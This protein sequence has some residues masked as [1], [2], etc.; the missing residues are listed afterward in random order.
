[1]V[2]GFIMSVEA[3]GLF[4]VIAP[5]SAK[6]KRPP[7]EEE[8][9]SRVIYMRHMFFKCSFARNCWRQ[10]GV[11]VP[12]WL[13][14]DRATR[15]IKRR[16]RVPFA[17]KIII[18]MYW[19]I[20]LERNVWIFNEIDPSVHKCKASFKEFILVMHRSKQRVVPQMK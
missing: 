10:V 19:C 9:V 20:W 7:E 14:V 16:L 2:M 8:H 17:M 3:Q 5:Q 1:M 6:H 13:R 12:T 4:L 15:Y 18:L 11:I